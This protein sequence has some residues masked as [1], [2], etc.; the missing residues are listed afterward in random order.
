MELHPIKKPELLRYQTGDKAGCFTVLKVL[1]AKRFK[2]GVAVVFQVKCDCGN[3]TQRDRQTLIKAPSNCEKCRF[4]GTA[5]KGWS[6]TPEYKRWQ[7]MILR[8]TRRDTPDWKNY[9]G[10]GISVH[11]DWLHGRDGMTG[12]ETFIADMGTPP[13]GATLERK[14]N[15]KGYSAENCIWASRTAQSRNRRGL[16]LV[17]WRGETHSVGEW[18]EI[19]GIA[20]FTLMRR[21]K[22]G[23][24]VERAMTEPVRP[25]RQE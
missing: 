24:P 22:A 15:N 18:A 20:Y 8:C 11:Q 7:G 25:A 10:R 4:P 21:I 23:W 9:G 5:P 2:A 6:R 19:T 3:I 1:G 17:S 16:R 12:L 13:T 14:D